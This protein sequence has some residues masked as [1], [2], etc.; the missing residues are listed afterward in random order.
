[1]AAT[2]SDASSIYNTTV[3]LL[4]SAADL[5]LAL[6]RLAQRAGSLVLS[7]LPEEIDSFFSLAKDSGSIIADAT[8]SGSLGSNSSLSATLD[9]LNASITPAPS[10]PPQWLPSPSAAAGGFFSTLTENMSWQNLASFDSIFSYLASRWAVATFV[11]V[12]GYDLVSKDYC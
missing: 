9:A 10:S 4:P 12:R 2:T 8:T 11:I 5:V 1:M 7:L 3:S 6:P